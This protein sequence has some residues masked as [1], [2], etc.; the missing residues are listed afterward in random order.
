[1]RRYAR[2]VER[3]ALLSG[4]VHPG[5]R[6]PAPGSLALVQAF[7]NSVDAEHGPDLFDEEGGLAEWLDRHGLPAEVR[8]DD[9]AV[10]REVR[11]A[12]RS[13]LHANNGAP[14]DPDAE[15]VLDRAA[16]RARLEPV[17]G[18]ARSGRPEPADDGPW[19]DSPG[20]VGTAP[21]ALVPGAG[22]DS[23]GVVRAARPALVPRAGGVEGAVGHV[24]AAAFVAML[25]GSWARLKAC[26]RE[27]CGWAF[28][29]R[30]SNASATWCSMSVCGGR[31]KAS[32]YYRRRR[33]ALQDSLQ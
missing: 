10:A 22:G 33:A 7:V 27:V 4:L 21:P 3:E 13:L 26:P 11:E 25:D 23:P 6:E 5:G 14:G 30:S 17:F 31:E 20:V 18:S 12:L 19:P 8:P 16:H 1:V 32:A 9:L 29:D 15:A 24:L 28:Y 2:T